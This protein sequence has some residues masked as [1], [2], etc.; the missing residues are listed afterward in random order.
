[1]IQIAATHYS[2]VDVEACHLVVTHVFG[3]A[4]SHWQR[5][6]YDY[7]LKTKESLQ[8]ES[9]TAPRSAATTRTQQET[10]C[11]NSFDWTAQKPATLTSIEHEHAEWLAINPYRNLRLQGLNNYMCWMETK[12]ILLNN[13]FSGCES[14]S[15]Y[16]KK[17]TGDTEFCTIT[18]S[19]MRSVM[20]PYCRTQL[21]EHTLELLRRVW[22]ALHKVSTDLRSLQCFQT[23]ES[24][25][26]RAKSCSQ[27]VC[28]AACNPTE[29]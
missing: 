1:M 26:M 12:T 2:H 19:L 24:E 18:G 21:F 23:E 25:N 15:M 22:L 20:C 8:P 6:S 28:A 10:C 9:L 4:N 14:V 17:T 13:C 7:D 5:L 27:L 3:I 16:H 29:S 11:H